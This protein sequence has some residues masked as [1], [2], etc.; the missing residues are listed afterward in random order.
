MSYREYI[1]ESVNL[2]SFV[3]RK[4]ADLQCQQQDALEDFVNEYCFDH[5]YLECG[6][7]SFRAYKGAILLRTN[8]TE[9][10]KQDSITIVCVVIEKWFNMQSSSII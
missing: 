2:P 9:E 5:D 10:E 6:V 3:G 7:E 8:L 4:V 1:T